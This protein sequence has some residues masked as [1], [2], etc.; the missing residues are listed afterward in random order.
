MRIDDI[1]DVQISRHTTA[2]DVQAF[3]VAMIM[4][5]DIGTPIMEDDDEGNPVEV[6]RTYKQE[7]RVVEY[8]NL[9][10]V[11]EVFG[12]DSIAYKKMQRQLGNDLKPSR[13]KIGVI[14][15]A[16]SAAQALQE[17]LEFD[18]EWYAMTAES[19]LAGDIEAIAETIQTLDKLYFTSS[20][21]VD[22]LDPVSTTDI[23]VTLMDKGLFRT[24]LMYHPSADSEFPED[25]WV[26]GNLSRTIGSFTWEYKTLGG[27]PVVRGLTDNQVA[28]L[29]KK[30]CNYYERVKGANITRKGKTSE[31]AW[32]DEIQIMDWLKVRLQESVFGSLVRHPKIPF[33]Q[34]GIGIVEAQMRSVFGIAIANTAIDTYTLISPKVYDIPENDR[35]NRI[36]GDFKFTARLSGAISKVVIRGVLTY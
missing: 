30:N 18:S 12:V 33:N 9:A 25:S 17:I 2:I 6:G 27:V 4:V 14:R 5:Q 1:V 16:E 3:D 22:I 36:A 24:V 23:A 13:V 34:D 35:I 31:G 20:S 26:G 11:G 10:A 32:I 29:L 7:L 28:T 15:E 19:H 8:S 21:N